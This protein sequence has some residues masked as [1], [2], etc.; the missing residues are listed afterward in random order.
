MKNG[1]NVIIMTYKNSFYLFQMLYCIKNLIVK[2]YRWTI[3]HFDAFFPELQQRN[4]KIQWS[5]M[6]N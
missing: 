6:I 3:G 2:E 4:E 1:S 5:N